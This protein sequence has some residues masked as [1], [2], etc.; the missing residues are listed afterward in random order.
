MNKGELV[1][2]MSNSTGVS[3]RE[4][5]SVLQAFIATVKTELKRGRKV[6][7]IGFGTFATAKRKARKGR[8]P[9]TGQ[10]SRSQQRASPNSAQARH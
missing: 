9:R 4:V 3:K 10:E 6:Q 7:L 1:E 2:K 8:N 5:E